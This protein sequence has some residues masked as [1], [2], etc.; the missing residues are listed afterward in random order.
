MQVEGRRS[1]EDLSAPSKRSVSIAIPTHNRARTLCETLA[2][3]KRLAIPQGVAL[4]CVVIDNASTDD[5]PQ[6]VADAADSSA[7]FPIRRVMEPR[8]GSSY[9]RNRAID[10]ARGDF[11]LF[12]DD[13]AIADSHWL[14]EMLSA[15]ETR[16]LDAACGMV[17]PRWSEPPPAWLGPRLWVKLAV[18]DQNFVKSVPLNEVEGL[19]NYFSANVGVRRSAF[20]RF[21]R[22]REDLG[23]VGKN[24]M[25]GEDTELFARIIEKGGKMGFVPDAIVHHL[26]PRERMSPEYLLRKSYAF[27]FGSA[28]AGGRSH[29][30]LDKLV[31][32]LARMTG[33]ALR[34]DREGALVHLLECANFVGYWRGRL[35]Q[36]RSSQL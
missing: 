14:T 31:K 4:E 24:P 20:E 6:A 1:R 32:N 29:N 22:F 16:G 27:G 33:A 34:N 19:D 15:M 9:A 25:S 7:P 8:Q 2:S 10:E 35:A 23:V 13:D 17:L 28:V 26:I 36:R 12:L 11:I 18:H 5:T 30:R 3:V 21:G